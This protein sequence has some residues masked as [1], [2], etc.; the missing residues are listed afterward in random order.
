MPF[1]PHTEADIKAMLEAIGVDS[2]ETLFDEIPAELRCGELTKV[3]PRMS[4]FEIT[5]LM[6]E[7]AEQDGYYIN[8]IGAGAYE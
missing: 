4:E 5:R 2:I 3:P 7:R 1:I 8:F 6:F